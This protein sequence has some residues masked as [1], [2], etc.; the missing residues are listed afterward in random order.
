MCWMNHGLFRII[1]EVT[2]LLMF[3]LKKSIITLGN[4]FFFP[5][6]SWVALFIWSLLI[7]CEISPEVTHVQKESASLSTE[8]PGRFWYY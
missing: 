2:Q 1:R 6:I 4:S 8:L 3:L 7:S 5:G